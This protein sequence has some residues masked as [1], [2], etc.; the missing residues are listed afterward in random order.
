MASPVG[1]RLIVLP[2]HT[3]PLVRQ[4]FRRAGVVMPFAPARF[5]AVDH[6]A[7]YYGTNRKAYR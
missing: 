1:H 5:Q 3:T 2:L 7:I 4:F 6:G